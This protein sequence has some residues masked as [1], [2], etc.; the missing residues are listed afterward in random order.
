MIAWRDGLDVSDANTLNVLQPSCRC[1][2]T[3]A[4]GIRELNAHDVPGLMP[5]TSSSGC[6]LNVAFFSLASLIAQACIV[7]PMVPAAGNLFI[8]YAQ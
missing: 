3:V 4:A 7:Q 8:N 6:L 5:T 2:P 1:A